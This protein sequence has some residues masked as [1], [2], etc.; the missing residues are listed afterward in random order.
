MNKGKLKSERNEREKLILG[1]QPVP[2]H[3]LVPKVGPRPLVP[4]YKTCTWLNCLSTSLLCNSPSSASF[5]PVSLCFN[6]PLFFYFAPS[7]ANF[8]LFR[9][10]WLELFSQ[11]APDF[12]PCTY[13]YNSTYHHGAICE[14]AAGNEKIQVEQFHT[15]LTHQQLNWMMIRR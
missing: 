13:L 12:R 11:F 4:D 10:F 15:I 9:S 2:S 8:D 6:F 14:D 5:T 7:R 3:C 1:K